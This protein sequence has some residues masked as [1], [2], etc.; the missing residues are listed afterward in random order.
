[1][2]TAAKQPH[3]LPRHGA[4]RSAAAE[5]L[6]AELAD[7]AEVWRAIGMRVAPAS[8]ARVRWIVGELDGDA[9]AR[10]AEALLDVLHPAGPA[11]DWWRTPLGELVGGVLGVDDV[12]TI[13]YA[14][15]VLDVTRGTVDSLLS[16]GEGGLVR[17]PG[18]VT[19]RSVLARLARLR[20]RR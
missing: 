5:Q 3:P 13:D 20:A 4:A 7:R 11:P 6:G 18:G 15:A 12:L 10:F 16:R 19:R 17:A 14:A 9:A 1:V 2:R 8:N